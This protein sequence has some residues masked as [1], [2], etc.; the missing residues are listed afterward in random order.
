LLDPAGILQVY[1]WHHFNSGEISRGHF[2]LWNPYTALGQ[3]HLANI[4][5]AV[6]FPYYWAWYAMGGGEEAYGVTLLVRLWLA[7]MF[8]FIFARKKICSLAGSLVVGAAYCCGGYSLWFMQLVDLN[9]QM[10]LPLLLLA[11]PSLVL[12]PRLS[13]FTASAVLVCLAILGG[14]PEA[15]FITVFVAVLYAIAAFVVERE[16]TA[17]IIRATLVLAGAGITGLL[18]TTATTLPFIN[19]LPR[20]WTMHGPGFGFF[21]LD[22]RAFF[23]LVVPGIHSIFTDMP[24]EIPVRYINYGTIEMMRLPYSETG[25]PGNL[26]GAGIVVCGLALIAIVKAR[27]LPW[28]VLFFAALL[29]I[30]LGLTLGLPLFRQIALIPP[31]NMN[32]NFKFFFSEIHVCL[33]VLAGVGL[34]YLWHMVKKPKLKWYYIFPISLSFYLCIG[35][36]DLYFDSYELFNEAN[37]Y[38]NVFRESEIIALTFLINCMAIISIVSVLYGL[39]WIS[40]GPRSL[41]IIPFII[42]LI[43]MKLLVYPLILLI[44]PPRGFNFYNEMR[45]Y[46]KSGERF[47]SMDTYWPA[48]LSM[49]YGLKDVRSSDALFYKPYIELINKVNDLSPQESLNYFYPSY[50]TRPS[51]EKLMS[52]SARELSVA[53]LVSDAAWLSDSII[54]HVLYKGQSI[55]SEHQPFLKI[56]SAR[57]EP[58]EGSYLPYSFPGLFLHA[59]AMVSFTQ[60]FNDKEGELSFIPYLP[61]IGKCD[62][63]IFQVINKNQESHSLL[64]SHFLSPLKSSMSEKF[65]LYKPKIVRPDIKNGIIE[66]STLPGPKNNLNRDWS[67]FAILS[68]H[69]GRYKPPPSPIWGI[70]A[71]KGNTRVT[72]FI[73]E[74][75]HLPWAHIEK[76]YMPLKAERISN[77]EVVISMPSSKG[78]TLVVHEAWYPGW[79]VEIDGAPGVIEVPEDK[80]SWRVPIPEGAK[81]AVF[82]FVPWDFRVGLFVSITTL[83]VCLGAAVFKTR[84][85]TDGHR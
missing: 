26:P 69:Q 75:P 35:M 42:S 4:Q 51:P 10:L 9:S 37:I 66:L 62:G 24:R 2:P 27:R 54:E 53:Y 85:N 41:A 18:L 45:T 15:A 17:G 7:G 14:H 81:K 23:N 63:T 20:C 43:F 22:P 60:P 84:I 73:Y 30:L 3:P 76:N 65:D 46:L 48:N 1:P 31:F 61:P 83:V 11:L 67:N 57:S 40:R 50:F 58:L 19:Y 21:H 13:T 28:P 52:G 32:S 77:S 80:V 68:W 6:M 12:R 49:K 16:K 47:S 5:T 44:E 74:I 36:G 25:V 59:P 78:E 55:Y 82:R 29:P 34:D 70:K 56:L 8:W 71:P 38:E 72:P 39:R 64:Y 33:A 79:T